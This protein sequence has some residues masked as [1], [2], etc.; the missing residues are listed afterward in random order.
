MLFC[1]VLLGVTLGFA[2]DS[3]L[4][5]AA[6]AQPL[7]ISSERSLGVP[8]F[9][10]YDLIQSDREGNLFFHAGRS[11][12]DPA[13]RRIA[14]DGKVTLY[15]SPR[16]L[17][18]DA[19]F[20]RFYVTR[21]GQLYTLIAASNGFELY[22]VPYRS[23]GEAESPLKLPEEGQMAET[24][25]AVFENG[26]I[27]VGGFFRAPD[28]LQGKRFRYLLNKNGE[29][30]RRLET[31]GE[32]VDLGTVFRQLQPG[33]IAEA[34][35]GNL[36]TLAGTGGGR[37][38]VYA[39]APDGT[40][41]RKTSFKL[42]DADFVPVQIFVDST[43]LALVAHKRRK[44]AANAVEIQV[45]DLASGEAVGR[46][47]PPDGVGNMLVVFSVKEGFKFL[48]SRNNV[49]GLVTAQIR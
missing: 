7:E 30:L 6:A 22:C 2:Q 24:E 19:Y 28:A 34:D 47:A 4:G 40:V 32:N 3:A 33:G 38:N 23:N 5:R 11:V 37:F 36:Y 39:I 43:H 20:R 9:Q 13:M 21:S 41:T 25:F 12:N 17:P 16:D 15:Q 18:K 35:D 45:I 31:T 1:L 29:L 10:F 49:L 14:S 44:R 26:N 42:L 27:L 46:Y 8:A 48:T